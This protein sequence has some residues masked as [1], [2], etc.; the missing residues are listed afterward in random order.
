MKTPNASET[1]KLKQFIFCEISAE[2]ASIMEERLFNDTDFYNQMT[3]LEDTLVD[4]YISGELKGEELTRFESGL[5]KSPDLQEHLEFANVLKRRIADY[6]E[7]ET[8]SDNQAIKTEASI[9]KRLS[10]MFYVKSLASQHAM[11]LLII[12]LG[13]CGIWLLLDNSKVRRELANAQSEQIE[14]ASEINQLNENITETK[15]ELEV[16][17][18][19]LNIAD[20]DKE[21]LKKLLAQKNEELEQALNRRNEKLKQNDNFPDSNQQSSTDILIARVISKGRGQLGDIAPKTIKRTQKTVTFQVSL[22]TQED[23]ISYQVEISGFQPK[24]IKADL[25]KRQICQIILPVKE[26]LTFIVWGINEIGE[27]KAIE[28]FELKLEK[29]K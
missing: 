8:V 3:G 9:W 5:T 13:V 21:D 19:R 6:K 11:V 2:E 28:T 18:E 12:L 15:R 7:S 24:T 16:L 20:S 25:C 1:E 14:R 29:K 10:K 22:Q 23:F 26:N 27:K 4:Q 17:Q